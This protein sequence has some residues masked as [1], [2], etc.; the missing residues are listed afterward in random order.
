MITHKNQLPAII[1]GSS[2]PFRKQLLEKL[3]LTFSQFSPEIDE[4]PLDDETPEQMVERLSLLKAQT[5][6]EQHPNKIIIA[7]DQCATF[8]NK[9]IGKPHT[10]ENAVKQLKNFSGRSI[11][12][13]TGLVVIDPTTQTAH[14]A[15]DETV[16]HFRELDKQTIE[17]YLLAETPYQCAGSFKSEGLGITLF[18]SIESKDP[19][20]L[21]G[22]PLIELTTLFRK[23]G[24]ILPLAS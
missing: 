20:A 17:N 2:S 3:Q 16:V 6:A 5:I 7:S 1:L 11:K 22:L 21:I 9:P 23:M 10:H 19:N 8:D 12:F 15:M 18:E 24:I 4:T 14:Q 13:Y